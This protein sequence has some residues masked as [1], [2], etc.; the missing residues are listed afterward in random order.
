MLSF[1]GVGALLLLF[2]ALA[3]ARRLALLAVD[4]F[5][6]AFRLLVLLFYFSTHNK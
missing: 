2:A 1:K 3:S 6:S 4:L 5:L